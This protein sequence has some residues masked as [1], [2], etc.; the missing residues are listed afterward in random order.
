MRVFSALSQEP[1]LYRVSPSVFLVV[2]VSQPE[3]L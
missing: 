2:A 1:K 3:I